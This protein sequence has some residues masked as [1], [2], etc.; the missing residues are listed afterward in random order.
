MSEPEHKERRSSDPTNE[1]LA[2]RI[3][4]VSRDVLLR[5]RVRDAQD[6][7]AADHS[8]SCVAERYAELLSL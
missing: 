8:F 2:E 4:A 7:Y 5:E 6:R 3:E 1:V